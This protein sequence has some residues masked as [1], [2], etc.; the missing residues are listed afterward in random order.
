MIMPVVQAYVGEITP[1][2]S[3]GYAMGL[4]NLSMFLSLSLGPL[5]GGVIHDI[6]TMDAAFVCMGLLSFVGVLLCVWLCR[7]CPRNGSGPG[8]RPF[9]YPGPW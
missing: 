1:K 3:E 4:F 8:I 6:W 9:R 7:R 5:M 2:G